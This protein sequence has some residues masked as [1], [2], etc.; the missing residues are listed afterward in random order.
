MG[1]CIVAIVWYQCPENVDANV[2]WFEIQSSVNGKE[3]TR[4]PLSDPGKQSFE[5]CHCNS[6]I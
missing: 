5:F 2:S 4:R 1:S 6:D 3:P